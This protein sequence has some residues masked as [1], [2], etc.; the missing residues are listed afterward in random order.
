MNL[1]R[2][3]VLCALAFG[4]L[5]VGCAD[6]CKS[7][8]D[9]EK[10]CSNSVIASGASCDTFCNDM[11]KL[12]DASSCGSQKDDVIDCEDGAKDVCSVD[13]CASQKT[14]FGDCT[15]KYC[16]AHTDDATCAKYFGDLNAGA[17]LGGGGTTSN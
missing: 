1:N 12:A 2:M 17:F 13:T 6:K 7:V 9:D 15:G 4:G 16:D 8:C 5:A 10:K 11:D 3:L 14:A